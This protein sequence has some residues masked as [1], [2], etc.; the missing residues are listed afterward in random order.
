MGGWYCQPDCLVPSGESFIRQ[1][2]LGREYFGEK[3]TDESLVVYDKTG[4]CISLIQFTNG[5]ELSFFG[6][7]T[8][9]FYD[10]SFPSKAKNQAFG[11]LFVKLEQMI[12][13]Q[14]IKTLKFFENPS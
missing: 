3:W 6:S 8:D 1:A 2:S 7:P 4:F 9:V 11:E 12:K 5:E 13:E 10:D 14:N